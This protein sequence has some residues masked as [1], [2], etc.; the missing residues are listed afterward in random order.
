ML[1]IASLWG[2]LPTRAA[3]HRWPAS[4]TALLR[5]L[6]TSHVRAPGARA[7]GESLV[8]CD[9]HLL[10]DIGLERIDISFGPRGAPC[11][12]RASED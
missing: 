8:D 6:A 5:V 11:P 3:Q 12:V 2:R 4:L 1:P 10:R 7:D 9:E